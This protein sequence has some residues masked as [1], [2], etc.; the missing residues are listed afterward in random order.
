MGEELLGHARPA[1]AGDRWIFLVAQRAADTQDPAAADLFRVGVAGRVLQV[2]R[3]PNGTT[4]TNVA[5]E[6]GYYALPGWT[7]AVHWRVRAIRS[8]YGNTRGLPV[9]SHGPWSPRVFP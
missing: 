1:L 9:V 4:I 2:A 8:T 6:R 5:D 7:G 3:L